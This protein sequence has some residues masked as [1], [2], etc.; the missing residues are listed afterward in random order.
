MEKLTYPE[1]GETLYR[2][3]LK[4][5]L[6]VIVV[7]RPG[8][9]KKLCYFVTDFGSIHTHFTMDGQSQKVPEGI[10][11]YLEHKLFDM[12]DRDVTAEFAAL[13][14]VPNAFT[15]YDMTAYYFSCTE[16][17]EKNLSL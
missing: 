4:N 12:P 6:S 9:T 10:A 15:G 3:T 2:H 7:P 17:F 8:F 13:G 14:A 5:G 16:H 1:L 11:H